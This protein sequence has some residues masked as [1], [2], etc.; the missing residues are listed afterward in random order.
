MVIQRVQTLYLLLALV[1]S[2][3]FI[4]IPFGYSGETGIAPADVPALWVMLAAASALDLVDICLFKKPGLQKGLIIV[5]ALL[6]VATGVV[7]VVEVSARSLTL[8]GGG[9][10]L[11][12]ALIGLIAAYRG[13]SADQKLLRSLDRIR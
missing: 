11:V 12:A 1:C 6:V 10:L 2:V 4:F 7:M 13:I 3:V 9:L 5:D 8:A